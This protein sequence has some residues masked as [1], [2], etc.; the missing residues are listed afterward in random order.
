MTW[1]NMHLSVLKKQIAEF[2]STKEKIPHHAVLCRIRGDGLNEDTCFTIAHAVLQ[3]SS[4]Q[5]CTALR[6]IFSK[7]NHSRIFF[8]SGQ[9]AIQNDTNCCYFWLLLMNMCLCIVICRVC[10]TCIQLWCNAEF[11]FKSMQFT[12]AF[13]SINISEKENII[14]L[15]I[16]L[17]RPG[18]LQFS[19]SP[20]RLVTQFV[21]CIR[22]M[23]FSWALVF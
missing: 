21:R 6:L 17:I 10:L 12:S 13:L 5:S 7:L 8:P 11:L 14:T 18:I 9:R 16:V 20:E 1:P 15:D 22:Q 2:Y 3:V 4:T 23:A 19:L